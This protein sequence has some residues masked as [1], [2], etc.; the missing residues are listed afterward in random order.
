MT[1]WNIEEPA[2]GEFEIGGG[3]IKPIPADTNCLA[4]IDEAKWS[5]DRDGNRFVSLRWS[6]LSP[7]DYKNRKVYQKLW[8]TDAD[9]K[10]KDADKKRS[11][12]KSMLS[13]ID[14]NAGGKLKAAG[15]EPTDDTLGVAL[16][17]KPMIIKI[18][19][20]KITDG[21]E[22]K[23]GNWIGK[24]SARNKATPASTPVAVEDAPF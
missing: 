10:A 9:P 3:E 23:S 2:N 11:K 4:T 18:M 22:T 15:V 8:V 16:I 7:A 13:A 21:G 12:A 6:V 20:W 1:F 17:N 14:F 24:V 5:E 19:E